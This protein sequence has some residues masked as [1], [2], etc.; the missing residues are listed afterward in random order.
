M[1][2][3][4]VNKATLSRKKREL[5]TYERFLPSLDLKRK[6]LMAAR[7]ATRERLADLEARERATRDG[8][9][10]AIPMLSNTGVDLEGL[11]SL[12]EVRVGWEN[13]VGVAAPFCEGV[14][15]ARQPYGLLAKPHWV[16]PVVERLAQALELRLRARIE[17]ARLARLEEGLR[18]VTQR[19]NLFD[20]VLIPET[21]AQIQRID[22]ALQ[23]GARAGDIRAKFAKRKPAGRSAP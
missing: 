4:P 12:R 9:G 13:V 15:I 7:N 5:A 18:I 1:A 8:L 3:E 20:Q 19:V 14:E 23:D 11:V 17:R 6:Q 21:Q 22:I 10:E 2:R 16:D